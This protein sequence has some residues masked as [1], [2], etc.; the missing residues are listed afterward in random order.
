[1]SSA[2]VSG[3]YPR[4]R[5]T[6]RQESIVT[7]TYTFDGQTGVGPIF[8]DAADF[9]LELIENRTLDGRIQELVHRPTLHV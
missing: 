2:V 9:D 1:M 3:L 5:S 4:T 6:A 7:A 8:Q